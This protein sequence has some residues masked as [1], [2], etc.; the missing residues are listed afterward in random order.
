MNRHSGR[1]ESRGKTEI[2]PERPVRCNDKGAGKR[3]EYLGETYSRPEYRVERILSDKGIEENELSYLR[4][5]LKDIDTRINQK[6]GAEYLKLITSLEELKGAI[7]VAEQ[8]IVRL[9]KDKEVNLESVTRNYLDTKRA[10]TRI[11]E[12]SDAIR[13]LNIDRTNLAMEAASARGKFEKTE[14]TIKNESKEAEGSRDQL[15]SLMKTIEEKK[16]ARSSVIHQQ[17]MLLE[18]SRMRTSERERLSERLKSIDGDI[19]QKADL[20]KEASALAEQK[21]RDLEQVSRDLSSLESTS[22]GKRIRSKRSGKKCRH[23]KKKS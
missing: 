2:L 9:Q 5:D 19:R 18:K 6:S 23:L 10:E 14:E 20:Q 21:N 3:T 8:T 1:K 7:K 22:F 11:G 12:C 15:F 13:N 16:G 4:S 17:D